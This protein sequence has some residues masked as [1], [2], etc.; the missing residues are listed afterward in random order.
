MDAIKCEAVLLAAQKGSL[1][2][3]AEIL[4]YTQSG[5]TR[6]INS[7]EEEIGFPVFIRSKKGVTLTENGQYLLPLLRDIVRSNHN[8]EQACSAIRG[9]IQGTLHIGCYFSISA[10]WMPSILNHFL[11]QYP[12]IKVELQEGGNL[13][14]AKWLE[15]QSVDCCFCARPSLSGIDW[16]PLYHDELVMWLPKDHPLAHA[17]SYPVARLEEEHFIHTM[18]GQ[19]NDLD[20][21]ISRLH[22]KMNTDFTTKD[23]FS[24][25]NMVEAGLGVSFNQRLIS[26]KWN[27]SVAEVPFDPPQYISLGIAIP[28]LADA[29]PAARRLIESAK[30]LYGTQ[31]KEK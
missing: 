3:A 21:L 8:A 24:T 16:I 5:V 17:K 22:L 10:L 1:T 29:S 4:G 28:S 9:I 23:A 26:Q 18:P 12:G 13:E 27:G 30:A 7:L 19:D 20:R 31:T 25:Y 6:M 11:H 2:E 15:E 14:M